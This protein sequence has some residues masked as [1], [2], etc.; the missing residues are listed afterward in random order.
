MSGVK[1]RPVGAWIIGA[2]L[3]W[4]SL[5]GAFLLVQELFS[6]S[7]FP[8]LPVLGDGATAVI[9]HWCVGLMC[10]AFL[11]AGIALLLSRRLAIP[12]FVAGLIFY[13]GYI[14]SAFLI[15]FI[16]GAPQ[17]ASGGG[18]FLFGLFAASGFSLLVAGIVFI[19][20]VKLSRSGVLR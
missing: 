10:G 20:L 6:D 11:I 12:F 13:I 14:T 17:F 8:P 7:L 9:A 18:L 4:S 2:A 16:H 5:S 15:A 1:T 3:L 19:Y